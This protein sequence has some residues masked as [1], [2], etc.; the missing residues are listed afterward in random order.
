MTILIALLMMLIVLGGPFALHYVQHQ[1]LTDAA[2]QT[3]PH[4]TFVKL[5]DG[6][7][8]C[9]W[10]GPETGPKVVLIH[11]FS[12]PM[13]VW[14]HNA[15]AL[16]AAG[17][18]VLR[19]DLYGRGYSDRPRVRYTAEL[20]VRQLVE[21]LDAFNVHEPVD[22]IGLSMGGGISVHVADRYP[23]RVRKLV[24]LAP[25]GF[26]GPPAGRIVAL[27]L[28]GEWLMAALG[29]WILNRSFSKFL[30]NDPEALAAFREEYARQFQFRGCIRAFLST[31]RHGPVHDIGEVYNRVG[32]QQRTGLLL[33]G[34]EDNVL[35][36]PL[37]E[38]VLK[39]MPWL[40]F[41]KIEGARHCLNYQD[42]ETVNKVLMRFFDT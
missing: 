7:T 26:N 28:V 15:P 18:R 4:K 37:H 17:F 23:E 22:L 20:F 24:L 16:A 30:G 27:P 6:V 35:P 33:W 5:S 3:L 10:L 38:P 2:R 39:A 19:Y 14:D 40:Q 41:E 42:S 8:H 25:V 21:L 36:F 34:T 32:R 9:E 13:F 29:E 1:K 31:M 11:G 12:S